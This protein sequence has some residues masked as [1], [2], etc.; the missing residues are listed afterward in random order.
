[1]SRK[2]INIS[3]LIFSPCIGLEP[4]IIGEIRLVNVPYDRMVDICGHGQRF[5]ATI[6]AIPL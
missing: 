4:K 5:S 2:K 3:V 6:P 1:M